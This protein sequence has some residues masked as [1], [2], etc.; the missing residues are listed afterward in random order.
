MATRTSPAINT[1]PYV[2]SKFDLLGTIMEE[3]PKAAELLAEYG[4]HCIS[5][6]ANQFDTLEMGAQVHGMT[7]EDLDEMIQEINAELE[8]EWRNTKI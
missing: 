1:S 2:L 8:Q 7:E 3:C 6:F 4:L 5:C